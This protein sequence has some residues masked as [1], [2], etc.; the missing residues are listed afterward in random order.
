MFAVLLFMV[1]NRAKNNWKTLFYDEGNMSSER[2]MTFSQ[3]MYWLQIFLLLIIIIFDS[4]QSI[5]RYAGVA[6]GHFSMTFL[7][8]GYC[9]K[10][11]I[12]IRKISMKK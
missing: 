11:N 12:Y 10:I 2:N 3:K 1:N 7:L 8:F 9:I 5:Y 6:K 4:F